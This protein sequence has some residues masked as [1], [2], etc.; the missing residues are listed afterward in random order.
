M[1]Y[2]HNSTDWIAN[3][4]KAKAKAESDLKEQ[5][6][7]HLFFFFWNNSNYKADYFFLKK[8]YYSDQLVNYGLL[9]N[10]ICVKFW[11]EA[12]ISFLGEK[13]QFFS[14]VI[15]SSIVLLQIRS[16]FLRFLECINYICGGGPFISWYG[17]VQN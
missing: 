11:Q 7:F 13:I 2:H 6:Y 17:C 1:R 5:K 3:P 12:S 4:L 10:S 15:I 16:F 9:V 14:D 8:L